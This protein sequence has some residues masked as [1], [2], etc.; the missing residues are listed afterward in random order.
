[1]AQ[2]FYM[3]RMKELKATIEDQ[4]L[5]LR[6][7]TS[8]IG[9]IKS[10]DGIQNVSLMEELRHAVIKTCA[11]AQDNISTRNGTAPNLE[12]LSK[13]LPT[14]DDL[15]LAA[16]GTVP[17]SITSTKPAA[18]TAQSKTEVQEN[19][20]FSASS[21]PAA[22]T[23]ASPSPTP[24]P[25]P[26]VVVNGEILKPY[27]TSVVHH[28]EP[29]NEVPPL[30][31]QPKKRRESPGISMGIGSHLGSGSDM[32]GMPAARVTDGKQED[33]T[34]SQYPRKDFQ[35]R[36]QA[37]Q[38]SGQ[39]M[40]RIRKQATAS[41]TPSVSE[42]SVTSR[43]RQ[44][45]P[46][47]AVTSTPVPRVVDQRKETAS[48]PAKS[49]DESVPVPEPTV[50]VKEEGS[51]ATNTRREHDRT[52]P[53][54]Y[55]HRK[56]A[57][58]NAPATPTVARTPS[59]G[60]K[61]SAATDEMSVTEAKDIEAR[62][63]E[64]VPDSQEVPDSQDEAAKERSSV[65]R[66]GRK[67]SKSSG[68]STSPRKPTR[69][70]RKTEAQQNKIKSPRA[71]KAEAD[72]GSQGEAADSDSSRSELTTPPASPA[73]SL[74]PSPV[75]R[76]VKG[77]SKD[78]DMEKP[79]SSELSPDMPQTKPLTGRKES[80][81]STKEDT[82]KVVG[83]RGRKRARDSE[84][85]APSTP[86]KR[87]YQRSGN[88]LSQDELSPAPSPGGSTEYRR[89]G[90]TDDTDGTDSQQ[91][92]IKRRSSD[93]EEDDADV[94]RRGHK[95]RISTRGKPPT[96]EEDSEDD[97][98]ASGRGRGSIERSTRHRGNK[99]GDQSSRRNAASRRSGRFA[100]VTPDKHHHT[101]TDDTVDEDGSEKKGQPANQPRKVGRPPKNARNTREDSEADTVEDDRG[102]EKPEK[103][104]KTSQ[105][106]RD[107]RKDAQQLPEEN[108]RELERDEEPDLNESTSNA[109]QQKQASGRTRA[110][111]S[112]ANA[113]PT[114][115]SNKA[116]QSIINPLYEE[117]VAYKHGP[118]FLNP[119]RESDAPG[120]SKVVKQPMDLKKI[121]SKIKK[122]EITSI[123]EFQRD[124]WL[125]FS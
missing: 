109:N 92:K 84:S 48:V 24:T 89:A 12:T 122:G 47:G 53:G 76:K 78:V 58:K 56:I 117:I 6:N 59:I 34:S 77:E 118:L 107:S 67:S 121:K 49:Q 105:K 9:A 125:V 26:S 17:H 68:L 111:R 110:T 113:T 27:P 38:A 96:I 101:N 93:R 79:T 29:T 112:T 75:T 60:E 55:N 30:Q 81:V 119:V 65:K 11:K 1:M 85:G 90:D 2:Y 70:T 41:P 95:R 13:W 102:S 23:T 54:V 86:A 120:Y 28:F 103:G 51:P 114:V 46:A 39:D 62:D 44:P 4:Q 72:D 50:P 99:E 8:E 5:Q 66:H 88:T 43:P 35:G 21:A 61:R 15:T 31:I 73:L 100:R 87:P 40:D 74:A 64:V 25:T 63:T 36:V 116:F 91:K 22:S 80:R 124:L 94:P 123:D 106:M 33:T 19:V 3:E 14:K 7:L 82:G 52:V 97:E 98:N 20:P 16:T 32:K 57:V 83:K 115:S 69:V 37:E 45:Q 108:Q 10:G 104:T 71:V 18:E 42:Q